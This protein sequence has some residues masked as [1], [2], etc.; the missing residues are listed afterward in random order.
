LFRKQLYFRNRHKICRFY[1]CLAGRQERT[2][3]S[4]YNVAAVTLARIALALDV[5]I[6][7]LLGLSDSPVR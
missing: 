2:L 1:H 5:D 4:V 6:N 7:Y 3:F